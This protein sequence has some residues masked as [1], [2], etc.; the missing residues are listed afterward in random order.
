MAS[1]FQIKPLLPVLVTDISPVYC[2]FHGKDF[3]ERFH[4]LEIPYKRN[5]L[6][7]VIDLLAKSDW[8]TLNPDPDTIEFIFKEEV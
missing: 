7:I 1:V 5:S 2:K 6:D 3:E 4:L 8:R